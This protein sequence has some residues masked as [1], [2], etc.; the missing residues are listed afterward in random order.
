LTHRTGTSI[1]LVALA[2]LFVGCGFAVDDNA[3]VGGWFDPFHEPMAGMNRHYTYDPLV[4]I[5]TGLGNVVGVVAFLPIS[6]L[7]GAFGGPPDS[8][9]SY[10]EYTASASA[11]AGGFLLGSPFLLIDFLLVRWWHDPE[12][13]PEAEEPE[14]HDPS[15]PASGRSIRRT[16]PAS[17]A[18]PEAST[19]GPTIRRSIRRAGDPPDPDRP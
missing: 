9:T 13:S 4:A 18:D 12:A 6:L 3:G 10:F 5:P 11:Y 2:P 7:S 14:K 19:P 15:P 16:G 1:L 17:G 8:P